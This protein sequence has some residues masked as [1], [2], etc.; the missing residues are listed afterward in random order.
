[1]SAL[2]LK[3]LL[4]GYEGVRVYDVIGP[5]W[6]YIEDRQNPDD[7]VIGQVRIPIDPRIKELE[8][9]IERLIAEIDE[10][11]NEQQTDRD[12]ALAEITDKLR[13]IVGQ[14]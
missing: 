14:R 5:S 7:E 12:Y 9:G 13:A 10:A 6:N 11:N 3:F 2:T 8:V 4:I 1:M